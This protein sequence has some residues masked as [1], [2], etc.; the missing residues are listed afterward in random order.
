MTERTHAPDFATAW[1]NTSEGLAIESLR[2]QVVILD[3]WT[4][5]CVN[6]MHL[7]PVLR[8]LQAR[9]RDD[10]LVVI[11]IHS[12]RFKAEK[13]P[14]FIASALRRYGIKHPVAVDREQ[15]VW[16]SYAVRSWPTLIVL[17]PD[18]RPG[19]VLPGETDPETLESLIRQLLDEGRANGTLA[20]K[21]L[22]LNLNRNTKEPSRPLRFPGKVAWG[23]GRIFIA[24]SGHHRVLVVDEEGQ[25]LATIGSGLRGHREGPFA[26]AA[27]DDPQGLAVRGDLLYIADA[28]AH[29]VW[30]ADLATRTLSRLAGTF[31]LGRGPLGFGKKQA[32]E[33]SLRSPWDLAIRGDE[34]YV[35]LAGSHQL[36]IIDLMTNSIEAIA[37]DGKK[38]LVDGPGAQAAL[39]QP[40]G[41]AVQGDVLYVADSESSGVRVLDLRSRKLY[42]LT[43]GPGLSD[44]GDL[45]GKVQTGMLQHP[46]AVAGTRA[47]GLLV[48]DTYNDKIKRFSPDGLRLDEFFCGASKAAESRLRHPAGLAVLPDG[49]VLVADTNN[50]RVVLLSPDGTRAF[51]LE[52]AGAPEP[53]VGVELEASVELGAVHV[54][55][56]SNSESREQIWID[57]LPSHSAGTE[58]LIV[59]SRARTPVPQP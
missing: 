27:L 49:E 56:E 26:Q 23:P 40:S 16:S 59:Q 54:G 28:G 36:A 24:D 29:V 5:S 18:G 53:E 14:Q 2:G 13:D 42:S 52:I 20:E 6:C 48:A 39:A 31:R 44:F 55:A 37:G 46:L 50:H 3:F 19:A 1:L 41:L 15:R 43:G 57:A 12:A 34:L 51:E 30:K 33:T 35:A 47:A 10:P 9:H 7:Q 11:G 8:E 21:P 38:A 4:S 58:A 22:R 45:T 25:V 32:T 17:R